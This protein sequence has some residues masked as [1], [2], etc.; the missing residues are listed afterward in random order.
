MPPVLI[1]GRY[2]ILS[3]IRDDLFFVASV[4]GETSPL[5]IFEFLHR[6]ADIFIDYFGEIDET[7]IKDNFST[8][9]QLLEASRCISSVI[10]L[11]G[12]L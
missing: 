1:H 10:R 5:L 6:V 2:H 3:I 8:V 7:T 4:T 12:F 9:Y 11:Y